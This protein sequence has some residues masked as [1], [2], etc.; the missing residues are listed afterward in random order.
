M[1]SSLT[2]FGH[3]RRGHKQKNDSELLEYDTEVGDSSLTDL[4]NATFWFQNRFKHKS[5][6][7]KSPKLSSV[8]TVQ[9][10][11]APC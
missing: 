2:A 7:H 6:T 1:I 8:I 9:W 4:N 3:W 11:F 5:N 10:M